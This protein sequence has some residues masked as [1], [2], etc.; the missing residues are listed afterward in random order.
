GVETTTGPALP[1]IAAIDDPVTPVELD[2]SFA[3]VGFY[4]LGR[5][6]LVVTGYNIGDTSLFDFNPVNAPPIPGASCAENG[7]PDC[8]GDPTTAA[9]DRALFCFTADPEDPSDDVCAVTVPGGQFLSFALDV[10]GAGSTTFTVS[11]N[12]ADTPM[13]TIGLDN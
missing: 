10:L 11:S 9:D 2:S 1:D 8:N 5:D 7:E 6:S 13:L 12:D 4:N 3:F